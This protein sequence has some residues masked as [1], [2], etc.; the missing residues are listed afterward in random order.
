MTGAGLTG[1]GGARP[2]GEAR[3]A[4][5][6]V[7][8]AVR[9]LDLPCCVP[10]T[11]CAHVVRAAAE[12]LG[13]RGWRGEAVLSAYRAPTGLLLGHLLLEAG[14]HGAEDPAV[15]AQLRAGSARPLT[16]RATPA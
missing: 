4:T 1:A 5:D 10:R 3:G 11:P 16:R 7:P 2:A 12:G 13:G 14:A 8:P 9:R 15:D 6:L